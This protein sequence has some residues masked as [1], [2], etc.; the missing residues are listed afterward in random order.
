KIGWCSWQ[1]CA[2]QRGGCENYGLEIHLVFA[3]PLPWRGPPAIAGRARQWTCA[4][5]LQQWVDG[6]QIEWAPKHD[7]YA[8]PHS[9]RACTVECEH[10]RDWGSSD[11]WGVPS[12]P[13]F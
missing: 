13:H 6:H 9:K 5:L 10:A 7:A 1:W 11:K 12:S 4:L 8:T 3:S 2:D